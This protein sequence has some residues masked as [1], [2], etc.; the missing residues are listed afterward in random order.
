VLLHW[1]VKSSFQKI[2]EKRTARRSGDRF[3]EL[4]TGMGPG[5]TSLAVLPSQRAL[6]SGPLTLRPALTRGLLFTD[7][8][9]R[10]GSELGDL[11]QTN[12]QS[13]ARVLRMC[14][15]GVET[16]WQKAK[17]REIGAN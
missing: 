4:T 3:E 8:L 2:T 1:V 11:P 17:W 9:K 14:L 15:D 6:A 12:S 7:L 5:L 13:C 16:R 10:D